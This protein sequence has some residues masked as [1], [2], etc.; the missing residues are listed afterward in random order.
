MKLVTPK[1]SVTVTLREYLFW[2]V[3]CCKTLN[4]IPLMNWWWIFFSRLVDQLKVF[5]PYFQPAELLEILNL[6]H[7][8][9]A[10]FVERS[11]AIIIV[12]TPP[13][14]VLIWTGWT[15]SISSFLYVIIPK[16]F[17][18]VYINMFLSSHTQY[19]GIPCQWNAFWFII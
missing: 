3:I 7:N 11:S 12:T 17:E 13:C 16:C 6:V 2:R 15:G 4:G 9:S 8:L 5:K 1:F 18:D 19:F 14:L 10:G